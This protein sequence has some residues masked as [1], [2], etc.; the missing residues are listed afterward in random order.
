MSERIYLSAWV[1]EGEDKV[2]LIYSDDEIVFVKKADFDRA[3][4][5][6]IS[7]EKMTLSV[8]SPSRN[9]RRNYQDSC[10][11]RT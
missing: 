9:R 11:K 5:A 4:G 6:I 3:F 1:P 2:K 10:K 8:I 7:A